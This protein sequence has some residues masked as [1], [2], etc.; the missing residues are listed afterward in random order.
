[1][2]RM[3]TVTQ[4]GNFKK[5][6]RFLHSLIGLHYSRKMKYYAELGVQALKNATPRDS[7]ETAN[8]WSYEIVE[9]PGRTAIYWRNSHV[10]NGA[11]IAEMPV[12]FSP[13]PLKKYNPEMCEYLGV[14]VPEGYEAIG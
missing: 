1:M 11:N 5:T 6:D 3:I 10:V 14:A 12:E 8:A 7:G 4:K 13:N 2:G 9:E